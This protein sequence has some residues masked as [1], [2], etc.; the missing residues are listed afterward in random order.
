M[1]NE[2][3]RMSADFF[4][5]PILKESLCLWQRL[6]FN[7][8]PTSLRLTKLTVRN[9]RFTQNPTSICILAFF[10]CRAAGNIIGQQLQH[11]LLGID[12]NYKNSAFS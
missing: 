11:L 2:M 12:I 9:P 6:S 5:Q 10:F 8:T 4:N 3:V 7:T 1:P